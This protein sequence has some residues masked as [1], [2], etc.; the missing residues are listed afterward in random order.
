MMATSRSLLVL[1]SA[2]LALAACKKKQP[3]APAPTPVPQAAEPA[4]VRNTTPPPAPRDTMG[5]YMEKVAAA[6][7]SLLSTIYFE[8]DSDELRDDSKAMLDAK[9]GILNANPGVRVRIAGHC[10]SRGSDEYNIALGR[11]RAEAAKRYL[12]DRGIDASRIETSSF[13]A[14]RPAVQGDGEEAW[15]KNR[16]DE[17]E[18]VAGGEQL[19]PA[20]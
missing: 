17:F 5:A 16:R 14:E 2:S 6:R 4:P 7:A 15:S 19:R 18:I 3:P 8:Y 11:R 10:D 1:V 9:I 13:G 20:R 12:T